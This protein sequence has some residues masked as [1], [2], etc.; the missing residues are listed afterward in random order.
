[1]LAFQA[2]IK[3]QNAKFLSYYDFQVWIMLP[4]SILTAMCMF[5]RACVSDSHARSAINFI[6]PKQEIWYSEKK[7][8]QSYNS[9]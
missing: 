5:V 4:L 8:Q 3:K 7:V 9:N 2:S 6:N 1:M